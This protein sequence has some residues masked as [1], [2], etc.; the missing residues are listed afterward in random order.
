MT[1]A[2]YLFVETEGIKLPDGSI[3]GAGI[4][5]KYQ[6]KRGSDGDY[7]DAFHIFYTIGA[8]WMRMCNPMSY[9]K[10]RDWVHEQV[11]HYTGCGM[12][13][14]EADHSDWDKAKH[15]KIVTLDW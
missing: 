13:L 8:R 1:S 3:Y 10:M 11:K 14:W 12:K 2:T 15:K 5:L 4:E 9:R 7:M 6:I